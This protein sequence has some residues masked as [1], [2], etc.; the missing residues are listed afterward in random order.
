M[1]VE[2]KLIKETLNDKTLNVKTFSEKKQN[3]I[4]SER[5]LENLLKKLKND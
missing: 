3:I 5:Q 1:K 2:K 4:I